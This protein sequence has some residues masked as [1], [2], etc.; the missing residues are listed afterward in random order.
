M[1]LIDPADALMLEIDIQEKFVPVTWRI[2]AVIRNTNRLLRAAD[3]VGIPVVAS[4]QYPE[5][6]GRTCREILLPPSARPIWKVHFNCFKSDELREAVRAS[7]RRTLVVMGIETHV[8]VLQSVLLALELGYRVHV[9]ADAVSSRAEENWRLGLERMR[10]EGAFIESTE[11]VL[12]QLIEHAKDLR[13][14]QLS[15][16]VKG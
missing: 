10:Q 11:M 8:C 16:I 4:E 3:L 14:R 9:A 12:F 7:G 2:D 6:L 1:S 13:F 15:D 5:G